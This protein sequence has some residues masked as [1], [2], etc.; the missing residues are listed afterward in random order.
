MRTNQVTGVGLVN[1]ELLKKSPDRRLACLQAAECE[2]HR[3]CDQ[4]YKY[5]FAIKIGIA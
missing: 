5:R 3:I 1:H 2:H 4:S